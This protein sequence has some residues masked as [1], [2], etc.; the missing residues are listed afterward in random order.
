MKKFF[1]TLVIPFL[2]MPNFSPAK[3]VSYLFNSEGKWIAFKKGKYLFDTDAEW[4]GW[5]GWGDA[6]VSDKNG[7][8]LGTITHK[9]RLYFFV[10]HPF[11]GNPGYPGSPAY[12]GR[13]GY[14][15]QAGYNSPPSGAQD[16]KVKR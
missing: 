5:M 1:L 8:Y 10:S 12:P 14:P 9:N 7:K 15:G 11:R 4:I 3:E 13:P 16:V 2:L 6:D